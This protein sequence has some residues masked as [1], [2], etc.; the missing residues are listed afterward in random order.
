MF[1][2]KQLCMHVPIPIYG[3]IDALFFLETL[4]G[5]WL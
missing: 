1:T 5:T 2:R 3:P 4:S